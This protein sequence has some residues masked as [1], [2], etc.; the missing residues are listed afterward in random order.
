MTRGDVICFGGNYRNERKMIFNG[1]KLEDLYTEVDDYGSVPPTYEVCDDGFDIG[2]FEDLIDHNSI[3][4][5][6][7]KKLK[8]I[9]IFEKDNNVMGNVEIK[10]K[11]WNIYFCIY[12]DFNYNLFINSLNNLKITFENNKILFLDISNKN[13]IHK[14]NYLGTIKDDDISK[15][16]SIKKIL[17]LIY[18]L[19]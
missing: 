14:R 17:I 13:N 1:E 11:L 3:N 8:E 2:D 4:W 18:L 7:L 10:G 5:L 15:L 12:D 19:Y 6:S 16:I 9:K